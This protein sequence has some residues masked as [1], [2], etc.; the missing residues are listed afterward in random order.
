[1]VQTGLDKT[2][3]VYLNNNQSQKDWR[4]GSSVVPLPN[5]CKVLSLNPSFIAQYGNK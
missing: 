2:V 5:K 1:M 4:Y 3:R